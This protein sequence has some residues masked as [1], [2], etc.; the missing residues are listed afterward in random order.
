M[1]RPERGVGQGT[2]S[3]PLAGGFRNVLV[4]TPLFI[5]DAEMDK[6]REEMV[7]RILD[8]LPPLP[9]SDDQRRAIF[10]A[11]QLSP[12]QIAIAEL[13]LRDASNSEIVAVLGIS[14]GTVKSYQQRIFARS[15]TRSRM[16]LAMRV[17]AVSHDINGD[18]H[19]I[20]TG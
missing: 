12:Q 11:L 10:K 8:S 20:S 9:L 15:G 13:M 3:M 6:R 14:D 2:F 18:G 17:L 19:G 7:R 1:P 16:Q 5:G 4:S